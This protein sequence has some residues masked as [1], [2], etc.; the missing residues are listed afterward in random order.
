MSTRPLGLDA[1]A[2]DD[3]NAADL[4]KNLEGCAVHGVIP[5]TGEHAGTGLLKIELPTGEGLGIQI[6]MDSAAKT[7]PMHEATLQNET[8][9]VSPESVQKPHTTLNG[10]TSDCTILEVVHHNLMD[11]ET[12]EVVL[13][14][15][16]QT[17]STLAVNIHLV[18]GGA[19]FFSVGLSNSGPYDR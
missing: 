11:P 10:S 6:P 15:D 18:D 9:H 2:S 14:L 3:P 5:G 1:Y 17:G 13:I 7:I 19:E 8:W 4:M 12:A 16:F